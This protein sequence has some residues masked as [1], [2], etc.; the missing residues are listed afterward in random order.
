[1]QMQEQFDRCVRGDS[2]SSGGAAPS[3]G[4]QSS[5]QSGLMH[6]KA[7]EAAEANVASSAT[8]GATAV[9]AGIA[10][11]G[12]SVVGTPVGSGGKEE[13]DA[14]RIA[15]VP[16][17]KVCSVGSLASDGAVA[18]EAPAQEIVKEE[19]REA[20]ALEPPPAEEVER[21]VSV[22]EEGGGSLLAADK[23]RVADA[24]DYSRRSEP[25]AAE[26]SDKSPPLVVEEP[27][28]SPVPAVEEAGKSAPLAFK[29]AAKRTPLAVECGELVGLLDL[30]TLKI[31]HGALELQG[32]AFVR[33]ATSAA[34]VTAQEKPQT[35][36]AQGREHPQA[37]SCKVVQLDAPRAEWVTV[38][39][40]LADDD[41]SKCGTRPPE[42][43]TAVAAGAPEERVTARSAAVVAVERARLSVMRAWQKAETAAAAAAAADKEAS[44]KKAAVVS[45][46]GTVVSANALGQKQLVAAAV[47][48]AAYSAASAEQKA[49]SARAAMAAAAKALQDA[50]ASI[51]AAMSAA[52]REQDPGEAVPELDKVSTTTVSEWALEVLDPQ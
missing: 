27:G 28:K 37:L 11:A 17:G 47:A 40:W 26:E 10:A 48:A 12:S 34:H 3:H 46:V 18:G 16:V 7:M 42:A 9:T 22:P 30:E 19:T 6:E 15:A 4:P 8:P 31:L 2:A 5:A 20:A 29:E 50:S 21:S 32:D 44:E 39:Q 41:A 51:A 45:A 49:Q 52:E 43:N 33:L 36:H 25:L 35:A 1:M 24:M 13:E 23:P 38:E 14:A